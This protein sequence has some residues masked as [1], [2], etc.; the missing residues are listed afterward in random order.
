MRAKQLIPV[1]TAMI[2]VFSCIAIADA[3]NYVR[4]FKYS[5]GPVEKGRGIEPAEGPAH[6]GLKRVIADD[7]D[8]EGIRL[9][10]DQGCS[11]QHRLGRGASFNCPEAVVE[12]LRP[13]AREARLFHIL[14]LEADQ[15]I[16][17]DLVW[18]EGITGEGVN[19]VILD[20]GI[21]SSHI[22]LADSIL[23]QKDFVNN[24]DIAED[25][26]G[27][28]THVAGIITA[29]GVYQIS[30][31]YATGVSPAA[32]IYMLKVC[33]ADGWCYEDD[34]MAAMEYAVDNLDARVMS[35]SIGGDNFGSH[36]DSD[37]VAAKVNWVADNGI[38]VAVAAG[39]E[40]S[41]VSSP[42][43][44]SKAIAV[45]AVDKAG[46]VPYW[47]NHG[48]ALDIVAPGV[49][50]LSTYSC[51]AAGD[52]LYYWYAY[53]SG[54]SM[55]APH[56]AGVAALLLQAKPT[57]TA[58]EVK[59]AMF[60][61]AVPAAG[62]ERCR[63]IW[64]GMC[65]GRT[66]VT[67]TPEEE[68]AG[69]V[70]A[71]GAYLAIKP[72]VACYSDADC[73][74]SNP[75]TADTC[76]NPGANESFCSKTPVVNGT[77][78]DDGLFC[79]AGDVCAGGVCRG[80]ARDCSDSTACTVD[81]CDEA[82]DVCLNSPDDSFCDDSLYCNGAETCNALLGCQPGTPV[83]CDDGNECTAEG[84][85]E[86]SNACEYIELADNTACTN[87]VCCSGSC[88]VGVL[89]CP[90]SVMCWSSEYSYLKR[91]TSQLRK[92][93]KCAEGTYGYSSYSYS[94]GR[95][96]AYQYIDS[97]DNENWEAMPVSTRNPAYRVRCSDGSWYYTNQDYYMG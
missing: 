6:R 62:C 29:N 26:N 5:N 56:I 13:G 58:D 38:V 34:M 51:L 71:Y 11:V 12:E 33:D 74:D 53:M 97:G 2:L 60:S 31:N 17:A 72:S 47:S 66:V 78:C 73:D 50:I 23:G 14:D 45:G 55:S 75:C 79:T 76:I 83:D 81:S 7:I 35:I 9:F 18:A 32:G 59:Q 95:K 77:A 82:G 43:C 54:T 88:T 28:G 21:D 91:A 96:S 92:F 84:C 44:A 67:C 37:P 25:D 93:C 27:H 94:L 63:G 86:D 89:E 1:V 70:D 41:G 36:C 39:N 52:C 69:I 85:N 87:G 64:R 20:S 48:T 65:I 22:E 90:T 68:G 49:D 8:E 61:T 3:S 80:A 16:K 15:Q 24:D 46:V 57:A 4:V 10:K 42:A 19:V 30:S 40:A